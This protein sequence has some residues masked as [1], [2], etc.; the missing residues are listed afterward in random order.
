MSETLGRIVRLQIQAEPLKATGRY[1]P[2]HLVT[3]SKALIGE[4]GMIIRN[5]NGWM[6][7]AHHRAH[8][9][10]RGG[11]NRALSIGFTGHYEAMAERFDAVTLGVAGENIIVDGPAVRMSDIAAG[12][13]I[14][15]PDGFEIGLEGPRPAAPCLPFTSFLVG[16]DDV[17]QRHEIAG[18]LTFLSNGTR[19]FLVSV[20]LSDR[21]EEITVGDEVRVL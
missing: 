10:A 8:P 7:D 3:A 9:T 1:Q 12:L 5:D 2:D 21:Y 16:S 4:A 20:R 15:R 18:E 13:F 14:R 19:G 11:G 6:V 17:L